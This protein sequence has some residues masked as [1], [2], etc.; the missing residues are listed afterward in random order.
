M[1]KGHVLATHVRCF[2]RKPS[3]AA[4]STSASSSGDAACTH[5]NQAEDSWDDCF[6]Q[7]HQAHLN[8]GELWRITHAGAGHTRAR[9]GAPDRRVRAMTIQASCGCK[10]LKTPPCQIRPN[11]TLCKPPWVLLR[12]SSTP[13]QN[14][15]APA[16]LSHTHACKVLSTFWPYGRRPLTPASSGPLRPCTAQK[17]RAPFPTWYTKLP[18]SSTWGTTVLHTARRVKKLAAAGSAGPCDS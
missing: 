17:W 14:A 4:P 12:Q 18:S 9:R 7:K 11:R 6:R 2:R 15:F 16:F 5:K 10:L 3:C 8:C 1:C 13:L